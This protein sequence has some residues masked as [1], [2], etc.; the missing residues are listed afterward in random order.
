LT[1]AGGGGKRELATGTDDALEPSWSADG[2]WILFT[3][4]DPVFGVQVYLVHPDGSG[5]RRLTQELSGARNPA[6]SPTGEIVY[7][8][9]YYNG[10]GPMGIQAVA[11]D[12]QGGNPRILTSGFEG[13]QG[14]SPAWSPDGQTML[15]LDAVYEQFAIT[16]LSLATMRYDTLTQAFGNRPGNWSPDGQ[17]IVFGTGDLW[18][19]APDG[20]DLRAILADSA[21]NFEAA[22]TP[23]A[24]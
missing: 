19:M 12:D 2:E 7:I 22:W 24:P 8:R 13:F 3:G 16:K 21:L 6:W 14:S 11:I 10:I 9:G 4:K 1:D 20:T 18:T 5:R 23:A 15:F 17:R